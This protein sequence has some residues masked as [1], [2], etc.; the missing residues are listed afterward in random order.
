[1]PTPLATISPRFSGV[2]LRAKTPRKCPCGTSITSPVGTSVTSPGCTVMSTL[3]GE[4]ESRRAGGLIR[5]SGTA[6]SSR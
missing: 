2:L 1:M 4:I 3:D 6:G 5:G